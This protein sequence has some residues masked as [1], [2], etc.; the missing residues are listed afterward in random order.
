MHRVMIAM[1]FLLPLSKL[2]MDNWKKKKQYLFHQ[3]LLMLNDWPQ[4]TDVKFFS[5]V[6]IH[7]IWE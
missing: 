4:I 7:N 6:A 5:L 2:A 1:F 3:Y